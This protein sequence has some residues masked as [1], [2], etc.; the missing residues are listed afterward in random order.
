MTLIQAWCDGSDDVIGNVHRIAVHPKLPDIVRESRLY[1]KVGRVNLSALSPLPAPSKRMNIIF[2]IYLV[3]L[4]QIKSLRTLGRPYQETVNNRLDG[5]EP[6]SA[7]EPRIRKDRERKHGGYHHD[8]RSNSR[9]FS[10]IGV[11]V[12]GVREP[13]P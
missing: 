11:S 4:T 6:D 8:T 5:K 3:G 12:D 2:W 9:Q 13:I 10:L 7:T 1:S